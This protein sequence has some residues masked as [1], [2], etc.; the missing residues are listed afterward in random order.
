MTVDYAVKKLYCY[1]LINGN[2]HFISRKF[3]FYFI[4]W[5]DSFCLS[6]Y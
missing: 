5:K 2:I 6:V 4:E 3:S 1:W